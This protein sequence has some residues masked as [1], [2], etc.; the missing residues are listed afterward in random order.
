M[1]TMELAARMGV[2]RSRVSQLE[3][4][5]VHGSIP[6]ASLE[7]AATALHCRV[8]Y[9]LVPV[10]PLEQLVRRQAHEQ[11]TK[12]VAAWMSAPSGTEGQGPANPDDVA[13][14]VEALADELLDRRGLWQSW[15][16]TLPTEPA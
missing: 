14:R 9:A 16:T 15:R 10:E 2:S 13:A 11:A 12:V 4:A 1:S 7:R 6:L 3:Q 8:C 5:E